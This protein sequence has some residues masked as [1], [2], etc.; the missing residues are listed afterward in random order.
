[1]NDHKNT[2]L[3]F[4]LSLIVVIGWE[5][6]FARPE[7]EK[8]AQQ[9]EQTQLNGTQPSTPTPGASAPTAPNAPSAQPPTQ[10]RAAVISGNA[11][12]RAVATRLREGPVAPSS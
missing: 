5:Y 12:R 7:M 2:I 6:Y 11:P 8:Q 3:A 4:V 9:Q 1:M 10:T